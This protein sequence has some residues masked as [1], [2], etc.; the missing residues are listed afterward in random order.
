MK[1]EIEPTEAEIDL[2]HTL[3]EIDAWRNLQCGV[4]AAGEE[5][6]RI[7][8]ERRTLADAHLAD[9]VHDLITLGVPVDLVS[10]FVAEVSLW[11][12]EYYAADLRKW[13]EDLALVEQSVMKRDECDSQS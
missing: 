11:A 3:A 9:T 10:K 12:N 6:R 13:Q 2:R 4:V 1:P 7:K 8:K 5:I